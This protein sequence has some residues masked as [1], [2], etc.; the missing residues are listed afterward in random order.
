MEMMCHLRKIDATHFQRKLTQ[1]SLHLHIQMQ[2][3]VTVQVK[4]KM[5][6]P[7]LTPFDKSMCEVRDCVLNGKEDSYIPY[8]NTAIKAA[9]EFSDRTAKLHHC[10]ILI[11]AFV[12]KYNIETVYSVALQLDNLGFDDK[13]RKFVLTQLNQAPNVNMSEFLEYF[14]ERGVFP[15]SPE[16]L[17]YA[18]ISVSSFEIII[19]RIQTAQQFKLL[20]KL[21]KQIT[22]IARSWHASSSNDLHRKICALIRLECFDPKQRE[23]IRSFLAEM[24]TMNH[25]SFLKIAREYGYYKLEV[26]Y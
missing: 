25:K 23:K 6:N 19:K 1:Q 26:N 10:Y 7:V 11:A 12:R 20:N 18:M 2:S 17:T 14:T 8:L 15:N 21:L 16:L 22:E 3:K 5:C 4:P 13:V 9:S 24:I